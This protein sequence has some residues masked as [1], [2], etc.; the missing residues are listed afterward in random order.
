MDTTTTTQNKVI[1]PNDYRSFA[2]ADFR[3]LSNK[4]DFSVSILLRI[5]IPDLLRTPFYVK[6]N[7]DMRV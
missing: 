2:D 3:P 1:D 5:P 6:P 7:F 4:N